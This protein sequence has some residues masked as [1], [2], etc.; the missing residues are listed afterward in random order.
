MVHMQEQLQS[1][2]W[3]VGEGGCRS[4][5]GGSSGFLHSIVGS[6][7]L[8]QSSSKSG[9]VELVAGRWVSSW[10]MILRPLVYRPFLFPG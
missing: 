6:S 10:A 1:G 9:F 8:F 2:L 3:S 7:H 4:C 5:P